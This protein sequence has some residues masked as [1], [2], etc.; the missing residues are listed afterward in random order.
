MAAEDI[1]K[2][3]FLRIQGVAR[4]DLVGGREPEFHIIADPLKLAALK[5]SLP[6]VSDA[7]I[8]NNLVRRR[9]PA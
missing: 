7:L 8:E 2:P 3:R 4:V 6:K 1:I 9:W 5:I